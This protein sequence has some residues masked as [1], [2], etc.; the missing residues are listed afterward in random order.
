MDCMPVAPRAGVAAA[1]RTEAAGAAVAA[2]REAGSVPVVPEIALTAASVPA[3]ATPPAP[4]APAPI[5][6]PPASPEPPNAPR[7]AIRPFSRLP[8]AI[9]VPPPTTAAVSMGGMPKKVP[10]T[11]RIVGSRSSRKPAS[12]RPVVG[13]VVSE[14]PFICANCCR[15]LTSLGVT[16]MSMLSLPRPNCDICWACGAAGYGE[17]GCV[18]GCIDL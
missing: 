9:A 15:P 11:P 8:V 7:P 2:L 6:K 3:P 5:P 14:P 4:A 10:A 18:C 12:G 1:G 17:E 13:L 16:C